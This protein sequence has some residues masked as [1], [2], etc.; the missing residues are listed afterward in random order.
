LLENVAL[1]QVGGLHTLPLSVSSFVS[2]SS[3]GSLPSAASSGGA[4]SYGTMATSVSDIASAWTERVG[5][6]AAYPKIP[7]QPFADNLLGRVRVVGLFLFLPAHNLR[8]CH[9]IVI[10]GAA[11]VSSTTAETFATI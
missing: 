6:V 4:N 11:E 1:N 10:S 5:K 7:D 8:T 2:F 9:S 3:A